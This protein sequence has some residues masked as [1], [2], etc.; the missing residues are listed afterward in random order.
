VKLPSGS[1]PLDFAYAVHIEI[2]DTTIG[3]GSMAGAVAHCSENGDRGNPA[4][5]KPAAQPHWE[6]SGDRRPR[7]AIRRLTC[8][9]ERGEL[10]HRSA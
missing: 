8:I 5:P 3:A 9:A 2:G 7:S 1:T 6:S 4:R 10:R